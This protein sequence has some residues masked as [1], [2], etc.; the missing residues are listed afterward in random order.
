MGSLGTRQT[1]GSDMKRNPTGPHVRAT[2]LR[3]DPVL[4]LVLAPLLFALCVAM[5]AVFHG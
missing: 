2:E 3:P 1:E 4:Y 5:F